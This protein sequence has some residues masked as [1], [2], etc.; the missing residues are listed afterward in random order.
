ML[1]LPVHYIYLY[2]VEVGGARPLPNRSSF[3]V[4]EGHSSRYNCS[5]TRRTTIWVI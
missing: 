2:A 4:P 1:Y 3:L 5:R